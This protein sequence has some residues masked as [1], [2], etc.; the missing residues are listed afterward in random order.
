LRI[1][2]SAVVPGQTWRSPANLPKKL[3]SQAWQAAETLPQSRKF[4]SH[5]ITDIHRFLIGSRRIAGLR[6]ESSPGKP[7]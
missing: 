7:P 4:G 2:A 6:P 1:I 5:A 3:I